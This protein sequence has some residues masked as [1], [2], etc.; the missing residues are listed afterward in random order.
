VASRT[1]NG[2]PINLIKLER[3]TLERLRNRYLRHSAAGVARAKLGSERVDTRGE[4][5]EFARNRVF[6]KHALGDRPMQLGLCQLEGRSRGLF[7]AARDRRLD[8]LDESTH[9]T[10]PCPIDRRALGRL[11]DALFR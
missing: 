3:G 7:I 8:L 4:P 5:G 9:S 11:A 10:G 1:K 6:V 2:T